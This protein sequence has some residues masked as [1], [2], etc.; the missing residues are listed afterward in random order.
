YGAGCRGAAVLPRRY[1]VILFD[2]RAAL[3]RETLH[4]RCRQ[5]LDGDAAGADR[6]D[7][8]RR[9]RILSAPQGC[10]PGGSELVGSRAVGA[11]RVGSPPAPRCRR[12]LPEAVAARI[13]AAQL[14]L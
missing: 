13:L 14:L 11:H 4:A 3:W 12:T 5:P 10:F 7:A 9:F 8:W 1:G 2:D 6:A